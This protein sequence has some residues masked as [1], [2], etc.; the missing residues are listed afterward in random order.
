MW[1]YKSMHESEMLTNE[2]TYIVLLH[3]NFILSIL[4]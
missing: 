4:D 2:H 1:L 3:L